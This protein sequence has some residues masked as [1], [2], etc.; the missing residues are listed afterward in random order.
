MPH[1]ST[2]LK[3]EDVLT[4]WP[5]LSPHIKSAIEHSGGELSLFDVAQGAINGQN[6]IWVTF[7]GD[8]L[9]TVIVTRFL[10]YQRTKMLQIM[11]C[12][13]AIED[14][15][16]WT[17]HH[18]ILEDFAKSNGCSAIE[19]WGR[20]GWGRRLKHMTSRKG[21]TYKPLYYVYSM[22]I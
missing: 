12:G 3:P 16:G 2:L 20:R 5:K 22:E 13:G 4:Y 9:I 15:D 8:K 6:H 18:R 11:T 14:W 21:D 10:D 17:E 7:S 19:I 1:N